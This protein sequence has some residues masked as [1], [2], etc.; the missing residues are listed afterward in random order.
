MMLLMTR[1]DVQDGTGGSG[2]ENMLAKSVIDRKGMC[3]SRLTSFSKIGALKL[4]GI[5]LAGSASGFLR[6]CCW[7]V[8]RLYLA[9]WLL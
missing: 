9:W 2:V 3:S 5:Y 4:L 7:L 6:H 1:N 8:F